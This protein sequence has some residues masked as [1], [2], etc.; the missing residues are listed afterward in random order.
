MFHDQ[1]IGRF[2]APLLKN[3]YD[4]NYIDILNSA[5]ISVYPSFDTANF[6]TKIFDNSW[7]QK[8][9]KERM[10]HI[11]STLHT[12][13]P[14]DF[15][16]AVLILEDSYAKIDH[17]LSLENTIFQDFIELYGLDHFEIS[18]QALAIFT[19]NST[20]EFAI[21]QFL[22]RYPIQTLQTMKL[23]AKNPNEQ[24]RRL[25]SEGSRPR[26]PWGIALT[27][28]KKD[29]KEII[30]ILEIL[31]DDSSLY[32]RKSV[33]NNLNDISKDNPDIFKEIAKKWFGKNTNR[34]WIIKHGARTLLKKA[35]KDML[36]LFGFKTDKTVQ[37]K[38]F[39]LNDSIKEDEKLDFSFSLSSPKALGKLRI[40]YAIDFV[41]LHQK[42][43]QK[44]FK[45]SESIYN[46]KIK[47]IS[48]YYSF[49]PI[50]TRKYYPGI[51][52][53]HI[54]V[55]GVV[56]ATKEFS[57]I[58]KKEAQKNS[59]FVYILECSDQ[60]LYTGITTNIEKRLDEHNNSPKGAKYTK[61]RRPVKLLYS[62]KSQNRSTASK[63]EYAI[64]QLTRKQKLDLMK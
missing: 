49:K 53:L 31:K 36:Q 6:K 8:T 63:R 1:K 19:I 35:D 5:I 58:K 7:R 27:E 21:R 39:T 18:M 17:N 48:K 40:E 46:Q 28:F 34:N 4:E 38:D 20:S 50:S 33:A 14:N 55:N 2:M 23:W 11:S 3:R 51:H 37:V 24:I 42:T 10:R 47:N 54:I 57:L 61:A 59:Y 41:R 12:F 60:T 45:I 30:E 9:L 26:L 22:I 16:Q 44:V 29:P 52:K 25:A 13:L 32:V 62:E 43:S 56:L 15:S 64:K